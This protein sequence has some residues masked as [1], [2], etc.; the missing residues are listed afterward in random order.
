MRSIRFRRTRVL[1]E[2]SHRVISLC[3][4]QITS[5]VVS[6]S[7]DRF[8]SFISVRVCRRELRLVRTKSFSLRRM[9]EFR[10]EVLPAPEVLSL[11]LRQASTSS[12]ELQVCQLRTEAFSISLCRLRRLQTFNRQIA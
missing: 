11:L 9:K 12:T 4:V 6:T 2:T 5:E 8:R 1:L 7:V 10:P 3:R